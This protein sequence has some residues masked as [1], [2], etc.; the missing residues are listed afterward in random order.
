MAESLS[1]PFSGRTRLSRHRS[2]QVGL[3][4]FNRKVVCW[5]HRRIHRIAEMGWR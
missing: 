2:A 5:I 3:S 1:L 4:P